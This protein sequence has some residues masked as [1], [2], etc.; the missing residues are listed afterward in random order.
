[1]R[2][3][4][5]CRL[6]AAVVVCAALLALP[7]VVHADS[8]LLF[9]FSDNAP[10]KLG[11]Q[12]TAPALSLGAHGFAYDV[13]WEHGRVALTADDESGLARAIDASGGARVIVVVSQLGDDTPLDD[14]ARSQ[15][16]SYA[17]SVLARF[18]SVNDIVIGNEPNLSYFWRPQ[19]NPDGSDASPAAYEALLARCYDVLHAFR[20]TINVAA[21]ATS[22][23][24]N[25]DPK[26]VSNIS[27]SPTTFIRGL[28]A[29]YEASG[30]TQRIFDTIVHHPYGGSYDERPYLMHPTP[31]MIGP[32]DW[33]KLVSIYQDA[34]ARTAQ[35]VPGRCFAGQPCVPIWY[36][37]IGYQTSVPPW[38]ASLY[39]GSENVRVIPDVAATPDPRSPTPVATSPAPDQA[40][41]LRDT[42]RLAY[43]QPY[44]EAVFNFLIRDDPDLGGYQS[45][46]LW[47][48][49]RPKR[50]YAAL[51]DVVSEVAAHAVSCAAPTAPPAPIAQVDS[52]SQVT[53]TWT[54]ASSPIGVSGYAVYRDGVEIGT[55]VGT[56]CCVNAATQSFVDASAALGETYTYTVRAFDA[57]GQLG[58]ESQP[59]VVM[60]PPRPL[61]DAVGALAP[62][63][64]VSSLHPRLGPLTTKRHPARCV[65]PRLR[66]RTLARAKRELTRHACRLGRVRSIRTRAVGRGRVVAQRPAAGKV[67]AR[68]ARVQ[69]VVSRGP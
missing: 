50:S 44:V 15:F 27:H 21:P 3:W 12:A 36:L 43:C 25:D 45:G 40:T 7:A 51:R 42:I 29:A 31:S 49:S 8:N 63:V 35:P 41:Q 6:P 26:A 54:L 67:L 57:A 16:C 62:P 28:A 10:M 47:T 61:L 9:G 23:H 20:P 37:E 38:K 5:V 14:T 34:F 4:L 24:G 17:K 55:S 1:M 22:P 64:F 53:L 69:L 65:V 33:N 19:Y 32:G 30:R 18:P 60:M 11:V 52:A 2:R 58:A 13:K 68:R 39:T 48:D 56:S 59:A 46:I 66:G